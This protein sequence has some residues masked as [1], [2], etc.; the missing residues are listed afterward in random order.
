MLERM[1]WDFNT[2]LITLYSRG[3]RTIAWPTL[4]FVQNCMRFFAAQ[5][6]AR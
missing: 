2:D 4:I 3:T 6:L 1:T 5:V